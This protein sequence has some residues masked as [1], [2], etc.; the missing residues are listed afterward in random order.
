MRLVKVT[1]TDAPHKYAAVFE[2]DAGRTRTVKFGAAGM[3][4][5][6]ITHDKEQRDRYRKRHQK[7]L[8]TNDPT[9]AGYLS[10]FLL[11]G[12][13]TSMAEN[14]SAYRKRFDL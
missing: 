10:R 1:P 5:Y 13:S 6:T 4:D 2:T 7:D 14:I 9:R 3:D 11:W 12:D 8:R